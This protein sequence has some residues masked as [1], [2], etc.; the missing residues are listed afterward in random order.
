MDS[1]FSV[2]NFNMMKLHQ[3][4]SIWHGNNET[5]S[6]EQ[7]SFYLFRFLW[8]IVHGDRCVPVLWR[9]RKFWTGSQFVFRCLRFPG[10]VSVFF[11]P[12]LHFSDFCFSVFFYTDCC[13]E[14]SPGANTHTCSHTHLHTYKERTGS[15][16][17]Q[18]P[19]RKETPPMT[20]NVN[21]LCSDKTHKCS[22][23]KLAFYLS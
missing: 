4:M 5:W 17:S 6:W 14:N 8:F 20:D 12:S 15:R 7:K 9:V 23:I 13:F 2:G 22:C 1:I 19:V 11:F 18:L 16:G 21:F 3:I 10:D